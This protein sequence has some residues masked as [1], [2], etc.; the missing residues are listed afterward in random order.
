MLTVGAEKGEVT[1][2]D[3]IATIKAGT[4]LQPLLLRAVAI[5]SDHQ[6]ALLVVSQEYKEMVKP[7]RAK[8]RK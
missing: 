7:I 3:V 6:L 1:R 5:M 4:D 2:E 8:H